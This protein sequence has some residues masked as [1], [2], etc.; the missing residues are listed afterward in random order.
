MR[1]RCLRKEGQLERLGLYRPQTWANTCSRTS[2]TGCTIISTSLFLYGNRL[3]FGGDGGYVMGSDINELQKIILA[4]ERMA[5][6]N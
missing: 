3:V 4:F 5:T 6:R 2:W 1:R